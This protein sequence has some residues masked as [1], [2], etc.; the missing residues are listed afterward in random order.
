ML[1]EIESRVSG[2]VLTFVD[3]T[4]IDA[5]FFLDLS[6][7][8]PASFGGLSRFL[9]V[10]V[11]AEKGNIIHFVFDKVITPSIKDCERDERAGSGN[12]AAVYQII[13]PGQ[14]RQGNWNDNLRNN[15]FKTVLN[16][17][18]VSNWGRDEFSG[19]IKDKKIYMIFG[20]KCF[21][22]QSVNEK[23]NKTEVIQ[24]ASSHEEANSKMIFHLMTFDENKCCDMY[25]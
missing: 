21:L 19:I 14:K 4:T 3:V 8:L 5:M 23:V 20:D 9:L 11:C 13:G 24:L 17:F 18:L 15:H 25:K 7:D 2:Y 10:Q 12:R 6:K 1:S 22:Y 16:E